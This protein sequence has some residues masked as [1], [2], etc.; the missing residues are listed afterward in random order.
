VKLKINLATL[1]V[2]SLAVGFVGSSAFAKKAKAPLPMARKKGGAQVLAVSGKPQI[3]RY[4]EGVDHPKV[5]TLTKSELFRGPLT[6]RTDANSEVELELQPQVQIKIYPE[7]EIVFPLIRWETGELGEMILKKGRV[8]WDSAIGSKIMIKSDLYE[9]TPG[10]GTYLIS[11]NP[12]TPQ[13]EVMSLD[14]E[15][16]FQELFGEESLKLKSGEKAHFLGQMEDGVIA[17]DLLL[18]GRKI[19]KGQ[20]SQV[21]PI[22]KEDLDRYSLAEEKKQAEV[23]RK[24][25]IALAASKSPA[26]KGEICKRPAGLFNECSWVC[27]K[28]PKEQSRCRMDLAQVQCVRFRCNANGQ[29]AERTVIEKGMGEKICRLS[30]VVQKC[31][32]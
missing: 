14:G 13:V 12:L 6:V 32:Y 26:R 27:E 5:S 28:N 24:K 16:D 3:I 17:Y 11:Y 15:I 29:W 30:A 9:A 25:A 10:K 18:Q 31:D 1:L 20:K 8:R 7:S 4:K 19:P 23:A 2:F 22:T 21:I